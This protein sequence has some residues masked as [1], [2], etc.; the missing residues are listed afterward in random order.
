MRRQAGSS[1]IRCCLA[2]VERCVRSCVLPPAVDARTVALLESG[3]EDGP[4]PAERYLALAI[5]AP[6]REGCERRYAKKR[7]EKSATL[8]CMCVR[9]SQLAD[10]VALSAAAPPFASASALCRRADRPSETRGIERRRRRIIRRRREAP[11]ILY[12]TNA[13]L[14]IWPSHWLCR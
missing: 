14:M 12:I 5:S 10:D 7:Q 3:Q 2:S 1:K 11:A 4:A 13:A 8:A 9:R 6:Y